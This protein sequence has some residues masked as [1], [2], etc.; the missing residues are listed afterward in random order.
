MSW[1]TPFRRP[2]PA[3]ASILA[4]FAVGI[5]AMLISGSPAQAEPPASR[6]LTFPDA[7]VEG[8]VQ[9]R[10][11]EHVEFMSHLWQRIAP[12]V[13]VVTV[14]GD[15]PVL[16]QLTKLSK[17]TADA[18]QTLPAGVVKM[19]RIT[20][21]VDPV[22]IAPLLDRLEVG[23]LELES[24]I[25]SELASALAKSTALKSLH[26]YR[27]RMSDDSVKNLA[28]SKTIEVL[29]IS[30][31]PIT[32]V[33]MSHLRQMENLSALVMITPNVTDKGY[34]ALAEHPT[35]TVVVVSYAS[36][37]SNT[38]VGGL[39]AIPNLRLMSLSDENVPSDVMIAAL[40]K[41]KNLKQLWAGLDD[42]HVDT[43]LHMTQLEEIASL[44]LTEPLSD[45]QIEQLGN[46]KHL[47]DLMV[48][49]KGVDPRLGKKLATLKNLERLTIATDANGDDLV[50]AISHHPTLKRLTFNNL[51]LA[52]E[53]LE[54]IGRMTSL[55]ELSL[56][57]VRPRRLDLK[58]I[59]NLKTLESL[60]ISV[61]DITDE[62][63]AS[64]SKMTGL[65]R[66]DVRG[67]YT[68]EGIAKLAAL[69]SLVWLRLGSPYLT[70]KSMRVIGKMSNLR[71][72]YLSGAITD[73]GLD[74]LMGNQ[75]LMEVQLI[76]S[77]VSK[78]AMDTLRESLP[79]ANDVRHYAPPR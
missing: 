27:G 13:G 51:R 22:A 44:Q 28:A 73:Q 78:A 65:L 38:G 47:R 4:S 12:T 21:E 57:V 2:R 35:L 23:V 71:M 42:R 8:E 32:D 41:M 10:P 49:G 43:L 18:L 11:L 40:V 50:E 6:T 75:S 16:V 52:N 25:G 39:A 30:G 55:Q 17:S 76:T 67:D 79:I 54:P 61:A 19:I 72:V 20:G 68:D 56:N 58:P 46:M 64:I 45:E 14:P 15:A 33:S 48:S 53:S 29:T 37:L 5:I 36:K 74:P 26:H 70:D 63:L 60:T 34:A 24:D 62:N 7:G 77:G 3:A 9:V 69:R 59:E 66:L 31:A 1:L